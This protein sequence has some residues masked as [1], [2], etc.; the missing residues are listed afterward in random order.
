MSLGERY[1][2]ASV[3]IMKCPIAKMDTVYY[4]TPMASI[5]TQQDDRVIQA[6]P[7]WLDLPEG[8]VV[9]DWI[10]WQKGRII[11]EK[12]RGAPELVELACQKLAAK[13]DDLGMAHREWLNLLRELPVEEIA[14]ILESPDAEGQRLRSSSP[15]S[16]RLFIEPSQ[17]ESIR[18][19]AYFG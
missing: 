11:A 2:L 10:Q 19:R 1:R 17:I 7:A 16:G 5:G 9:N 18:E 15:F 8:Y 6:F 12:V 3:R 4:D 13:E 14:K